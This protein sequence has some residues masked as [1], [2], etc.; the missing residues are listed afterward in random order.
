MA[1]AGF[2]L[3]EIT[4]LKFGVTNGYSSIFI[5]FSIILTYNFIGYY[6]IKTNN[7]HWI[8]EWYKQYRTK[9]ILLCGFSILG[10][11]YSFFYTDFNNITLIIL[12]LF[13]IIALFYVI[14]IFNWRSFEF[15]FRNFPGLKIFSIS[16]TWAGMTVLFPLSEANY[17]LNCSVV[18]EFVQ[19]I[20]FIIIIT[21]PFDIRDIYDDPEKLKTI[22]QVIGIGK[23]KVLGYFLILFFVLLDILKYEKFSN[24][25]VVIILVAIVCGLVLVY[26]T[27]NRSRYFTVFLVEGIP[28][29]WFGLYL[30]LELY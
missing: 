10:L 18:L 26:V 21:L 3:T 7:V 29:L 30:F 11:G 24:E 19:R 15:S 8:K 25:I 5:F 6:E 1:I 14:P 2:C 22:P 4:L 17:T 16:V 23:T 28:V 12:L 9:I 27:P 20:I 13:S